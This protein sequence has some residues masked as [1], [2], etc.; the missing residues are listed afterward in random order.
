MR[1]NKA[2]DNRCFTISYFHCPECDK[3]LTVPR[4]KYGIR[5]KGHKKNIWCPFCKKEQTMKENRYCDNYRNAL[6]E[7]LM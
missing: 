1:R 7:V 2:R 3:I 4:M 6:G 5:E